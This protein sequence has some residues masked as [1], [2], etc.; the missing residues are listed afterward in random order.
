MCALLSI[1]YVAANGQCRVH[2]RA[3]APPESRGTSGRRPL[4][5][6]PAVPGQGHQGGLN[7]DVKLEE[8]SSFRTIGTFLAKKIMMTIT[9]FY[10]SLSYTYFLAVCQVSK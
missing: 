5:N 2:V 1:F 3:A 8:L 4:Q 10:F 9:F 7:K 6:H